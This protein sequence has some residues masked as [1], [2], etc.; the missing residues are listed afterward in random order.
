MGPGVGKPLLVKVIISSQTYMTFV[1]DNV[2]THGY[3]FTWFTAI[4]CGT[5]PPPDNGDIDLSE[6]SLLGAMATYSCDPSFTLVGNSSRQCQED[7]TWSGEA[8][9]CEG[10]H[11]N[12]LHIYKFT[13]FLQHICTKSVILHI[14][15]WFTSFLQHFCT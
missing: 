13:S 14:C 4:D 3:I 2:I 11:I 8:P 12:N 6:G 1:S 5:L 15:T 7:E 9:T 10:N